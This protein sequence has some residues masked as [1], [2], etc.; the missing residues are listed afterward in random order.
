MPDKENLLDIITLKSLKYH[1]KH[2][3]Y[4]EE[5]EKGNHFEVDII[6]RG[7]F[8]KA[9]EQ[10]DLDETFNYELADSTA[11]KIFDGTP[12]K[13]IET[14]CV[15]IGNTL[16]DLAPAVRELTVS[17]RKLNPPVESVAAYAEVTMSWKR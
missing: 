3:Y 6:A 11:R 1:G 7:F 15:K 12:E 9:A 16:F 2:G 4:E 8:K 10:S 13:L 5:R 17:V 14:L